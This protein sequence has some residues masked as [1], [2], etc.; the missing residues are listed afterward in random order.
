MARVRCWSIRK[1]CGNGCFLRGPQGM[2]KRRS[3]LAIAWREFV[4]AGNTHGD[5]LRVG[6]LMKMGSGVLEPV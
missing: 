5:D 6:F 4:P 1:W 2:M 3:H